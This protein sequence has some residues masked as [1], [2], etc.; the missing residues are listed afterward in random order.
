MILS[1]MTLDHHINNKK[2]IRGTPFLRGV[3][4]I[5]H[6]CHFYQKQHTQKS[7]NSIALYVDEGSCQARI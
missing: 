4:D 3:F 5:F 1:V 7:S 2:S 6:L